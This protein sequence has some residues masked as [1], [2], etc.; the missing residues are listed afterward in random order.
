LYI[1]DLF[2]VPSPTITIVPFGPIQGDMVGSHQPLHCTVSTVNGVE[3]NSVIVVWTG[4][5]GVITSDSRVTI[6]PTTGSST[7]DFISTLQF[8]YLMEGD[9]GVYQCDV[10]ILGT[11]ASDYI[12]IN[13]LT[14]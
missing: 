9:E 6:D 14:G 12:E 4:P 3:L 2:L 8:A 7:T 5:E 11:T 13:N 1:C 10:M